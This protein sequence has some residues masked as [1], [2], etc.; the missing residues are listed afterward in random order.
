MNCVQAHACKAQ[1]I[2]DG[3]SENAI[4]RAEILTALPR[5][6]YNLHLL[7]NLADVLGLLK[8]LC[9]AHNDLKPC[10]IFIVRRISA[11][12]SSFAEHAVI[13]DMGLAKDLRPGK[14]F[15]KCPFGV[16][17]TMAYTAPEVFPYNDYVLTRGDAV[18]I[19]SFAADMFA[20]GL[21]IV[22]V[23]KGVLPY[24]AALVPGLVPLAE[25]CFSTDPAKRPLP[26]WMKASL[27]GAAGHMFSVYAVADTVDAVLRFEDDPS[28]QED[29]AHD[30][31]GALDR[32]MTTRFD[33][34]RHVCSGTF[35]TYFETFKDAKTMVAGMKRAFAGAGCGDQLRWYLMSVLRYHAAEA[36]KECL[37]DMID[38]IY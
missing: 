22:Q 1:F 25:E 13:A 28:P 6:S 19:C 17:G 35:V 12:G 23:L 2:E 15:L 38:E 21:V 33:V 24:V 36:D 4:H 8:R 18:N 11:D 31:M 9:I 14:L 27:Q 30:K 37:Q 7:V 16:G 5:L 29:E 34:A 26:C 3:L 20:F 10:N 32:Y